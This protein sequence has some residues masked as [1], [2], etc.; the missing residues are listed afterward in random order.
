MI[1]ISEVKYLVSLYFVEDRIRT[2][3]KLSMSVYVSN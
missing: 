3:I 2:K 1:Y